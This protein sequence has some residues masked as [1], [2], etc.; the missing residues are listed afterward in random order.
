MPKLRQSPRALKQSVIQAPVLRN[1]EQGT[2][3]VNSHLVDCEGEKASYSHVN[4]LIVTFLC[5]R[6]KRSSLKR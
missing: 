2:P 4:T 6:T 1:A 3:L 5:F